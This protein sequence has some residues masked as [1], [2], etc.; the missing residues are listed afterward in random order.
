VHLVHADALHVV[1]HV[2]DNRRDQQQAVEAIQQASVA[3]QRGGRTYVAFVD[4]ASPGLEVQE[5]QT[6]DCTR[7]ASVSFD[8]VSI[9]SENLFA[10]DPAVLEET[11]GLCRLLA[12]I[13]AVGG[14]YG[15]LDATVA[16]VKERVQFGRQIGSFQAVKHGLADARA[17]IEA[18]WLVSWDGLAKAA[19][20][21]PLE[22]SPALASWH[23][24]RAFQDIAYKGAQY[25]G[26]MGHVVES[27]MQF[28]Y[29]R[30]GTLH[31]RFGSEYDMLGKIAA[32]YVEPNY[33]VVTS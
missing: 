19:K 8:E 20:G 21:L 22:G 6:F 12:A 15:A 18:A 5:V 28:Y 32:H 14:A 30:A 29:R 24:K 26:G 4:L 31:G 13:E 3:G 27:H 11:L 10:V 23:V 7:A 16:H 33:N 25:H 2:K 1:D 17:L 9:G